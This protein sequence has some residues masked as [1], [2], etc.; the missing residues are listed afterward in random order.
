M[1]VKDYNEMM[2]YLTRKKEPTIRLPVTEY[3]DPI[4]KNKE[5][6][7]NKINRTDNIRQETM[8]ERIERSVYQYDS[9]AGMKKPRH[10]D[11]KNIKTF[12]E[13]QTV[14]KV[15]DYSPIKT[16]RPVTTPVT[17]N[18]PFKKIKKIERP[19]KIDIS[20]IRTD[21][22][23]YENLINS[24]PEPK[25]KLPEQEKLEGIETI[26]NIAHPFKNQ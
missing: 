18:E 21:L 20:G 13:M 17:A 25:Y 22:N 24:T 14:N 2:A 7:M 26:L 9:P 23:K 4:E 16:K 8:P 12:E 1:K 5:K 3:D 15:I 6:K 10:M 19:V 11:N